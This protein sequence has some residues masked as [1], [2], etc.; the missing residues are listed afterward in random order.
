M[1]S[2]RLYRKPESSPSLSTTSN[3]NK[4]SP[5]TENLYKLRPLPHPSDNSFLYLGLHRDIWE[6]L[7]TIDA[8]EVALDEEKVEK[9][10]KAA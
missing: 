7:V 6:G 5:H 2:E 10:Q 9:M 4:G 8:S 1:F 3:L